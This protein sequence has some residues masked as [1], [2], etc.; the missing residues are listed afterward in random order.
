MSKETTEKE[1][2]MPLAVD[3]GCQGLLI[4]RPVPP[5]IKLSFYA[6]KIWVRFEGPC[7]GSLFPP[8]V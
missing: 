8:N 2:Q 5:D 7:I 3:F 1:V 6:L 4:G